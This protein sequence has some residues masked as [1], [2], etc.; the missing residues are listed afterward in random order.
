MGGE[1]HDASYYFKCMIGGSLAC[2]LTHTAIVPLDVMKCKKQLDSSFCKGMGDGLSKVKANGHLT[3]G[4]SPT[5]IGYSLQGLGKFGFYE[6]FKDVY[7]KIVGEEKA[8]QYKKVGWSIASGSAEIIADLFLCPW[9]ATKLKIQLSRPGSEFPPQLGAALAHFKATEGTKGF[10]SGIVPLWSRQVPYT[11]VKFVAFEWFVQF[12]Y[13]NIFTKGKENYSK[14]TQL[15][16]TFASGYLAGIFCAI[17]S[18]P[19]DT[20]LSKLVA[21]GN[22]PGSLGHKVGTIYSEIGF[23]GLWA[24]LVTRIIM[25][26]TLTGLQWWIYDSFKTMVGLQT[27]GG[28]SSKKQ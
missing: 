16:V 8:D 4:W 15:G 2:G 7:K 12:F 17:I 5:L 23:K 19:A 3:L 6:M 21:K 27:T 28:G 24:G 22:I 10:Y 18:H 26:G 13:D 14:P 20:I 1:V 25:I 11:I 9:E